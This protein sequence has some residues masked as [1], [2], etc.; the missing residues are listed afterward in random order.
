M[1]FRPDYVLTSATD[2]GDELRA[3]EAHPVVRNAVAVAEVVDTS[4]VT[5]DALTAIEHVENDTNDPRSISSQDS[6][7]L[8]TALELVRRF[9]DS[10]IDRNQMPVMPAAQ[11][12][13]DEAKQPTHL[14]GG[15]PDPERVFGITPEGC[16]TLLYPR[17]S[18][19]D[20]REQLPEVEALLRRA[21]ESGREVLLDEG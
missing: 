17:I 3:L 4:Q 20:L 7:R 5:I 15:R 9:L 1:Y 12:I 8:A 11:A 18:L 21:S 2:E 14:E 16:V 19:V 6:R 10:A 13:L